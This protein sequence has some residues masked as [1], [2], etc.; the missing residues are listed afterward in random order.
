M[1]ARI[2][3]EEEIER[4]WEIDSRAIDLMHGKELLDL[5]YLHKRAE[6]VFYRFGEEK[7]GRTLQDILFADLNS[8]L[9]Y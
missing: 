2:W 7:D 3:S 4:Q 1:M 9:V 8:P 5:E 6:E